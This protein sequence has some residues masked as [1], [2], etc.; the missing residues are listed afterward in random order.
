MCWNC[1]WPAST[2]RPSSTIHGGSLTGTINWSYI[3]LI[4]YVAA[5]APSS[6][7][8]RVAAPAGP[9][10]LCAVSREQVVSRSGPL[11]CFAGEPRDVDSAVPIA[12]ARTVQLRSVC[13][14][15]FPAC[16]GPDLSCQRGAFFFFK[17]CVCM[18]QTCGA[19]L[20]LRS[21]PHSMTCLSL[22]RWL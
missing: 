13:R 15:A 1:Y 11:S 19:S 5:S 20:Y 9:I 16:F 4:W 14:F 12:A 21:L 17:C 10:V 18:W 3:T 22:R 7:L 6:A 2:S 8:G